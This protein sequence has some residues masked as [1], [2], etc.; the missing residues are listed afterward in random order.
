LLVAAGFIEMQTTQYT[1][2]DFS[3]TAAHLALSLGVQ[4]IA[5]ITMRA[6]GLFHRHY[7]ANF[8]W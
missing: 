3:T 7:A 2:A 1:R 6:I 4:V 8:S 5:I